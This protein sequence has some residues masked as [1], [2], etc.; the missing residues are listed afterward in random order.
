[1]ADE[2]VI[3]QRREIDTLR[4]RMRQLEEI[5]MPRGFQPPTEWRLTGQE[6]RVFA[7]LASREEASKAS[8]MMALYSDRPDEEPNIKIVHVFVCKLR[9]KLA[10]FG[11][12][13]R[14]IWGKGYALV[15]R[16]RWLGRAAA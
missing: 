9:K 15:D 3:R 8:I 2:L 13:V 10:P 6:A 4:E 12:S 5:L 14:T 11:V 16:S 1:M 7:H